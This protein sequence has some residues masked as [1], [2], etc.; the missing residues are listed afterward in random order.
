MIVGS[1]SYFI[2]TGS[3]STI[4]PMFGISNQLLAAVA[5]CIA[6]ILLVRSGKARYAWVTLLPLSFVGVTT[7]TA[8]WESIRDI[9]YP[10]TSS[11]DP[12]KVTQGWVNTTLTVAIMVL[13][14]LI[15]VASAKK[16]LE[17]AASKNKSLPCLGEDLPD[18]RDPL[19]EEVH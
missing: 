13:A 9:F 15:V 19:T 8:G 6:T 5:L 14:I 4:W 3:I 18:R 1:W 7:L 10:L 16:W 17:L 11:G 2:Y 12:A